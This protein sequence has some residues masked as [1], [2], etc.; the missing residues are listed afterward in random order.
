MVGVVGVGVVGM[1]GV[2]RSK[3]G[4][5]GGHP[6]WR[7]EKW[8]ATFHVEQSRMIPTPA[9]SRPVL[10]ISVGNTSTRVAAAHPAPAE[11]AAAGRLETA[12]VFRN[13]ETGWF[14]QVAQQAESAEVALVASVN[15]PVADQLIDAIRARR[16]AAGR[17]GTAGTLPPGGLGGTTGSSAAGVAGTDGLGGGGGGGVVVLGRGLAVPIRLDLEEPSTVGVDRLLTALGAYC[18]SATACVVVDA[19]TAVTVDLIDSSG[20]FRGGV[21]VP[22]LAMMLRSLHQGTAALPLLDAPREADRGGPLGRSTRE[23]MIRGCTAAITGLV[24]R[25]VERYAE[26]LGAYPRVIATGG[27]APVLFEGDELVEIIVPDLVLIGMWEAW[28]LGVKNRQ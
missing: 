9:A 5:P 22:G 17:T 8:S 20:V 21:I 16:A 6:L 19:G 4:A 7:A 15:D 1:V 2:G 12:K 23:A 3:V 25:Q 18:R 13:N 24:Y 10:L 14:E 11:G 28:R 26:L 27:D